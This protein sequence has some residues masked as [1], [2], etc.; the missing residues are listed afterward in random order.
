MS[1]LENWEIDQQSSLPPIEP[2]KRQNKHKINRRKKIIKSRNQWNLK[3]KN[4]RE[5]KFKIVIWK[6]Q[7]N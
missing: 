4:N 7:W 1:S 2:K 6:V 3:Q 5:K